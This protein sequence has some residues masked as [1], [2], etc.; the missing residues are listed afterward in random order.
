MNNF[1]KIIM[2]TYLT[3]LP[4]AFF[5]WALDNSNTNTPYLFAAENGITGQYWLG[6]K[7]VSGKA[8]IGEDEF[9][10]VIAIKKKDIDKKHYKKL[11]KNKMYLGLYINP[12]TGQEYNLYGEKKNVD[13]VDDAPDA[14]VLTEI[15]IKE[16]YGPGE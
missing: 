4:I 15:A 16:D 12:T 1:K 9:T 5:A 8:F 10:Q 2:I 14:D 11:R 6:N 13:K 3:C 7:K